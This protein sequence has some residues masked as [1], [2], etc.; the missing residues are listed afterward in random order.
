MQCPIIASV[1]FAAAAALTEPDLQSDLWERMASTL[2]AGDTLLVERDGHPALTG[3]YV[4][5]DSNQIILWVD[6]SERAVRRDEV[7]RVIKLSRPHR[8]GVLVGALVGAGIAGALF[9]TG[10]DLDAGGRA[11]WVSIG[12]AGGATV[13]LRADRYRKREIN[14]VR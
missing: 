14:Y 5:A 9:A 6:A 11:L 10:E 3:H 2:A 1:L 13:G 7:A 4:S 8:H 12:A